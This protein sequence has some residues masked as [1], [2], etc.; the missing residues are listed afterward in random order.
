M[1]RLTEKQV[2]EIVDALLSTPSR[3]E[4]ARRLG[5][6]RSTLYEWLKDPRVRGLIDAHYEHLRE[7]L[8]AGLLARTERYME[9]LDEL[10]ENGCE[11]TRLRLLLGILQ[12]L[13]RLPEKKT[14][15][16]DGVI[17]DLE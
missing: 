7:E 15:Y 2:R 5:V 11:H 16:E 17:G 13:A 6:A 8:L 4:A 10:L 9:I 3:T 12:Q 1:K 14:E